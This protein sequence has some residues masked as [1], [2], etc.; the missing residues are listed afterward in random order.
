MTGPRVCHK[1]ARLHRSKR[2]VEEVVGFI[3]RT[4]DGDH[5][6]LRK[7]FVSLVHARRFPAADRLGRRIEAE[8]TFATAVRR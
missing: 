5:V 1:R 8:S 2:F 3:E 4:V 7:Q 6:T